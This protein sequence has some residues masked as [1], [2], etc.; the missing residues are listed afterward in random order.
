[1]TQFKENVVANRAS[2]HSPLFEA[3]PV[4]IDSKGTSHSDPILGASPSKVRSSSSNG[5]IREL[6]ANDLVIDEAAIATP[7]KLLPT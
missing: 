7:T 3:A 1:M 4:R 6:L 5:E 2:L